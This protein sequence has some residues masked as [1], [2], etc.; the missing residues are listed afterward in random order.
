MILHVVDVSSPTA[1]QQAVLGGVLGVLALGRLG[2]LKGSDELLSVQKGH[3][4]GFEKGSDSLRKGRD[5]GYYLLIFNTV[6]IFR[7]ILMYSHDTHAHACFICHDYLS[8]F[9]FHIHA[10]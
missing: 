5:C 3:P 8:I 1:A 6:S 9:L 7:V 10:T 2:C 4:A